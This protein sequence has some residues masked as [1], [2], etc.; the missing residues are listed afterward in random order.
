M[1]PVL[2][3]KAERT[4]SIDDRCR[5]R[6]PMLPAAVEEDVVG[7]GFMGGKAVPKK[8]KAATPASV[9]TTTASKARRGRRPPN[10]VGVIRSRATQLGAVLHSRF[11]NI[12]HNHGRSR[13]CHAPPVYFR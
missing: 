13:H 12:P 4:N 9:D 7:A 6:P 3:V 8:T 5:Q 1:R 2:L 11:Q 10:H